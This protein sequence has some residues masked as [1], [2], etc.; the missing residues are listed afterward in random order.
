[1]VDFKYRPD[2]DGLR[3]VAVL[4]VLF[5]H[6]GL[7]FSGGF[8]GV[9]VFFVI[10]GFLITGLILKEQDAG[11][12]SL[13]NFWVRRIRRILPAVTVIAV[14]V[15]AVGF[16]LLLPVDYTKLAHS[17]VAQ[18]LML[19]NFFFWRNTG[20]FGGEADVMPLLHTWSLA[21]EEQFYLGYPFLLIFLHRFGRRATF[22]ALSLLVL[23]SLALSEYGVRHHPGATFF[24][25]P[26]RAWELL[27]GGLIWF[28]PRTTRVPVWLLATI[29]WLSLAAI[30]GAGWLYTSTTPFPGMAALVPCVAAAALIYSNS[31]SLSFPASILA[32]RPF[33]FVGLISYSLYLWHWPFLAF[34]R[35]WSDAA[36]NA[37]EGVLLLGCSFLAAILSWRFVEVPFRRRITI[38]R[39]VLFA[40]AGA[41]VLLVVACSSV[42]G[43]QQGLEWRVPPDASRIANVS[44]SRQFIHEI[45]VGQAAQGEFAHLGDGTGTSSCL[46]WGDS[47]A[48]ALAPGLNA[49]CRDLNI[50]AFQATHSATPPIL[51][52]VF[53]SRAGGLDKRA[54]EFNSH[55]LK[56]IRDKK[57]ETVYLAGIWAAYAEREDF[58][59]KLRNTI[60]EITSTGARVAVILD[61]ARHE[62]DVPRYF[63]KAA[64]RQVPPSYV[65]VSVD[66]HRE[67]NEQ[68]DRIIRDCCDA[69]SLACVLDP[70]PLF[71]D[72]QGIWQAMINGEVMY[73]DRSH[74]SPEGGLHLR[75]LFIQHLQPLP[76]PE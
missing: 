22:V 32:T 11:K 6:A 12:F 18:Q 52:F 75:P 37:V 31:T 34:Y 72:S 61:V 46:L 43:L 20:Y 36:L 38:S 14:T 50:R 29:S 25:L 10:S 57:V 66:V 27:I 69:N 49:A 60:N 53:P 2:V 26:T 35:Y 19:S 71:V 15:L 17:A 58:E 16:F 76:S 24:F 51:E 40:G 42:I 33:V 73:R 70:A 74:L 21:V 65:G 1:M 55:V 67:K 47:H 56:F 44:S 59:P 13:V 41:V 23:S 7:G 3:A 68:A 39:P 54:P 63:A 4:L 28:L 30:L 45:E 5:F 48:M 8:I 9:D 62:V 64:F